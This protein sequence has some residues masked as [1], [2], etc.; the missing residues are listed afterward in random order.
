MPG[1]ERNYN[2]DKY[3]YG[4]NG[5]EKDQNLEF[6][7]Q[8][9]YDY[10]FRIYNPAIGKFLSVDPLTASYPM[11]TPYQ[12]AS[13]RPIDGID[14]DGK[15]F[16][17]YFTEK[18]EEHLLGT[19]K[20]KS[21]RQG[22]IKR[23]AKTA[24]GLANAPAAVGE[25]QKAINDDVLDTGYSLCPTG[26][27]GEGQAKLATI[28]LA[29][30]QAIYSDAKDLIKRAAEGDAEA[31][32]EI[33]FEA[34]AFFLPFDEIRFAGRGRVL[35]NFK[36]I[37]GK[38][39]EAAN[40]DLSAAAEIRV[41]KQLRNE[42]EIIRFVDKKKSTST[43]DFN[44]P[45]SGRKTDVKRL[46]GLGRNAAGD[47][48]KGVRQ[49]G[50]GGRVIVVRPSNSKFTIEQYRNSFSPENFTPQIKGKKV[51]VEIRVIN[52]SEL[53]KVRN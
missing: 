9:V 43:P 34:G 51:N 13:N 19:T 23:A 30:G 14:L 5:K 22:F 32:G 2:S 50:D 35:G 10:G 26:D 47:V 40:G 16:V 18:I 25:I 52:E 53:P 41:A 44:T 48:A 11:L 12:F 33:A 15:E 37:R 7:S 49:V 1:A 38:F 39:R 36:T 31:L 20:L 28:I 45:L 46:S 24:E 17:W 42:G 3:R 21:V 6:G 27:C 4:F 8:T 29:V